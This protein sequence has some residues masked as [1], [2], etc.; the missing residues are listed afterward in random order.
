[1]KAMK[2][3]EP[4]STGAAL[5]SLQRHVG[6][7]TTDPTQLK[8]VFSWLAIGPSVSNFL[9]PFTAGLMID[10]AGFGSAFALMATLPIVSWLLI[11]STRELA[12]NKALADA[13]RQRSWDLLKEPRM[14]RLL[15]INWLLSSCWDVHTFV[16]PVLGHERGLS[17]SVIG[18]ILGAFAVAATLIRTVMPMV[19]ARIKEWA[20]IAGAM[21]A[22]ALLFAVYP[23][24]HAPLAMGACSVLLGFALGSVQPMILST[25]HQITPTHR[26]GEALGLRMMTINASSVIMPTLFGT[27]GTLIGITGVFWIVGAAVGLGSRTAWGLRKS[28][29]VH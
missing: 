23:L 20:V 24:L 14:R 21:T 8:K 4:G 9:G 22:T 27:L 19:A 12:P 6:C 5:I 2:F 25:L 29:G 11:R 7:M 16:L 15:L 13:P 10:H 18:T 26:H 28:L 17:A 1:M 3:A